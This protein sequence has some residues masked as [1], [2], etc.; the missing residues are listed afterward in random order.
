MYRDC[1]EF[2]CK[3]CAY[4]LKRDKIFESGEDINRYI[5]GTLH[6]INYRQ[7][8]KIGTISI[9]TKEDILNLI[10]LQQG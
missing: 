3:I 2:Y 9:I 7:R 8:L 10:E 4:K 6:K 1:R 5:T